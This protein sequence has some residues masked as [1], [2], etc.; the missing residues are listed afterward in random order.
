MSGV[1]R[2]V[3]L[4]VLI[5]EAG[6]QG[7]SW[8]A[9]T[10]CAAVSIPGITQIGGISPYPEVFRVNG[11]TPILN[12]YDDG[13]PMI[14]YPVSDHEI[15]W[16][17][18]RRKGEAKETWRAMDEE[19]RKSS[20]KALIPVCPSVAGGSLEWQCESSR[21]D[22]TTAPSLRCGTKAGSSS[23]G[24]LS[25]PPACC[26][27]TLPPPIVGNRCPPIP[28]LDPF[29]AWPFTA[30][31]ETIFTKFDGPRIARTSELIKGARQQDEQRVVNV[32]EAWKKRNQ[33]I[34][35]MY[36]GS[37]GLVAQF[38]RPVENPFKEGESEI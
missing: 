26:A 27:S 9:A 29:C 14:G 37:G 34:A 15:S 4:R 17:I 3:L 2:P 6:T 22:C 33:V 28:I 23:A 1:R 30:L 16:A 19:A 35:E 38:L 32:V 24:T 12:I 7:A 36:S 25:T 5:E 21:T 13:V 18:T 31:L 11:E 20:E 10:G 8:W